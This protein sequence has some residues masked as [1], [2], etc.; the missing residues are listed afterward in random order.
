MNSVEA[1]EQLT[2]SSADFI[3]EPTLVIPHQRG[4][5][6]SG[7]RVIRRRD[8]KLMMIVT[9]GRPPADFGEVQIEELKPEI[10]F[11]N[12][13]GRSWRFK[14]M[15]DIEWNLTG[16][17][18]DGGISLLYLHDG[19]LAAVI[20]R[21]LPKM[22]GGGMPIFST[23]SDDGETW[24][25]ARKLVDIDDVFYVM[26][27]RLRQL[28]NGRLILPVAHLPRLQNTETYSEGDVCESRCFSSDDGGETWDFSPYE[29]RAVLDGDIRGMAEPA[30]EVL[31]GENLIML[32]RTG[33]G[34]LCASYSSDGGLNW[35]RPVETTLV[36]PCSS[37]ALQKTPDEKLMVI[38]NH[39]QPL[40]PGSF[41]PRN[42]LA[43][44]ISSDG[45]ISWSQPCWIDRHGVD[46]DEKDFRYVYPD[47]CFTD[48]GVLV[49]YSSHISSV[50]KGF[51]ES[52][53]PCEDEGIK[54]VM[55]RY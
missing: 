14:G 37:F 41:F 21:N 43:Y 49:T 2:M 30:V 12:D 8:G 11:S 9:S 5:R 54:S 38:Y 52:K 22:H 47:I 31:D 28:S 15:M 51:A 6:F 20:H 4:R 13:N 10:Y 3:Y 35:T 32:A 53:V 7:Q 45:G 44:S 29:G 46:S 19:R 55:I 36:S 24:Q 26:N 39:V 42:P 48:E 18:S 27:A 1:V 25:P 17:M 34:C 16:M 23:S 40:E 50:K 33:A